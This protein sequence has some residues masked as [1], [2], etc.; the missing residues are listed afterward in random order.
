MP[1]PASEP[2]AWRPPSAWDETRAGSQRPGGREKEGSQREGYQLQLKEAE[3]CAEAARVIIGFC[4]QGKGSMA[5]GGIRELLSAADAGIIELQSRI[6]QLNVYADALS[7]EPYGPDAHQFQAKPSAQSTTQAQGCSPLPLWLDSDER[8]SPRAVTRHSRGRSIEEHF[9]GLA[10]HGETPQQHRKPKPAAPPAV[11][12][13]SSAPSAAAAAAAAAYSPKERY[14]HC[15]VPPDLASPAPHNPVQAPPPPPR[16]SP[17]RQRTRTPSPLRNASH[18]SPTH[19][20]PPTMHWKQTVGS[21]PKTF[22]LRF[23]ETE[24]EESDA[25]KRDKKLP[26]KMSPS[27]TRC[28]SPGMKDRSR[29]ISPNTRCSPVHRRP[30]PGGKRWR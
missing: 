25:G 16:A 17:A 9:G 11:A 7:D 21:G 22:L 26:P 3:A 1:H 24:D 19:A 15:V 20:T 13:A 23:G 12:G 5:E 8:S 14:R 28:V 27:S 30:S 6:K 2:L 4:Q 29:C 18:G 10:H